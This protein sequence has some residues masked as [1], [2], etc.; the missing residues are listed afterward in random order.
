MGGHKRGKPAMLRFDTNTQGGAQDSPL[1][2]TTW[3]EVLEMPAGT[4]ALQKSFI[5]LTGY[6]GRSTFLEVDMHK[7][8]V[9]NMDMQK[10]GEQDGGEAAE[11]GLDPQFLKLLE[12]EKKFLDQA[13]QAEAVAELSKFLTDHIAHFETISQKLKT[14][15]AAMESRIENLGSDVS[16]Y[17]T[18]LQA[19]N[20]DSSQFD[21][22]EVKSHIQG[23]RTVLSK[24][25]ETGGAKLADVNQAAHDL[26]ARGG[27]TQITEGARKK[28]KTVQV[29]SEQVEQFA[30]QGARQTNI[31]MVILIVAVAGLGSLF[32][33]RMRYYEKKHY[34]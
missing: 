33:G 34:I 26:K 8:T 14:D 16:N 28:A 29:Q 23:I 17:L 3:H 1:I 10:V 4:H 15:V 22:R 9:T 18:L 32:F 7:L 25:A 20:F 27:G 30:A 13:T 24:A 31:L 5:G 19:F 12:D 2:P 11:G 21:P 6:S